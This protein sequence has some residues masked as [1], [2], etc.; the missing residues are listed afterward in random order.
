MLYKFE[1]KQPIVG[2]DTYVSELATV[3]GNVTIG[4]NCYIGP[5]AILRGDYGRIEI[6]DG[7]AV[8]EGVIIHAPPDHLNRIGKR[9]TLGHGAILHGNFVDNG[10]VI[11]MGTVLSIFSEIGEG[12]IVAEGSLVKWGKK[13]PAN[14]VA[15]GNPATVKRQVSDK[16]QKIWSFGKQLYVDLAKRYLDSGLEAVELSVCRKRESSGGPG[17]VPNPDAQQTGVGEK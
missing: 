9:V 3:I 8:E 17:I 13:I 2:I 7:T 14:S 4:N 16:D 11:G 5:K 12:A 15:V 1:G 10:A 6:G